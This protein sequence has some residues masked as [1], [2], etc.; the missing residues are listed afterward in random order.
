MSRQSEERYIEVQ[1]SIK[2]LIGVII[3][4]D[5]NGKKRDGALVCL[6]EDVNQIWYLS[7]RLVAGRKWYMF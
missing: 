3:V 6:E 1:W 4:G 2:N 5:N 7:G